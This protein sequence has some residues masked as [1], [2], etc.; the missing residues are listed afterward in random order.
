MSTAIPLQQRVDDY[1]SERR[2]LGFELRPL[3]GLL[4]DFATFLA[5]RHH[6]GPLSIGRLPWANA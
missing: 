4:T 1:L 2:Q 3:P 6:D 5:E